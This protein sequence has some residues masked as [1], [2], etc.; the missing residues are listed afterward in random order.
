MLI[1]HAF[2]QQIAGY[3]G[4][5]FVNALA[6]ID[7]WWPYLLAVPVGIISLWGFMFGFAFACTVAMQTL[8]LIDTNPK[9]IPK[10]IF[11]KFIMGCLL[12]ILNKIGYTIFNIPF[13]SDGSTLFPTLRANYDANILD[14]IAWM[15]VL[16]PLSIWFLYGLFRIKKGDHLI[17]TLLVILTLWFALSPTLISYGEMA[18]S[19]LE[20]KK[21]YIFS[22]IISKFTRG[23]FRLLPGLGYGFI[24]SIYATLLYK[25]AQFKKIIQF[26]LF[27]FAY[28][29]IAFVL[30]IFFIDPSW[31]QS[32]TDETVPIPLT[33][34][35]M[36]TMQFLFVL[37]IRTHDYPK[38]ETKRVK[39][40]KRTTFWRRFSV[41][42]LSAFSIGTPIADR[43][44]SWFVRFWGPSVDYSGTTGVFA[45][46]IWQI[47]VF[48]LFIW[49]FWEIIV[50]IWENFEYKFSLDWLLAQLMAMLTGTQMNRSDVKYIIYNP[51]YYK[52]PDVAFSQLKAKVID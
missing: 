11:H 20:T 9:R 17:F 22:L 10:Y 5:L 21:L 32:F 44:F 14:A 30:W 42:S 48:V 28:C 26:T 51:N 13:F 24:G 46:T 45:W 27:F 18:I 36:S 38:N 39:A 23:R 3:D 33:I 12:L 7:S 40:S 49:G 50:R 41:F 37:F 29:M 25:Q 16:V 47:I 8:R 43:I 15:G 6:Q 4:S 35:S 34:I 1:I 31:F 19:Y 52:I 2:I